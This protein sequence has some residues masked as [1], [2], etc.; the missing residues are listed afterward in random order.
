[1][2]EHQKERPSASSSSI[3]LLQRL[4]RIFKATLSM[5]VNLGEDNHGGIANANG[6]TTHARSKH[7]DIQFCFVQ[8]AV[9][10]KNY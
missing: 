2:K 3:T 7:V 5:V 8:E 4:I 1:M 6:P 9:Q 10:K